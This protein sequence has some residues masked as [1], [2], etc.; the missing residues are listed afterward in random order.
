MT[1]LYQDQKNYALI[2]FTLCFISLILFMPEMSFAATTTPATTTST[3]A[4]PLACTINRIQQTLTGAL[5]K[6]IATIAIVA[7]GIGLFLGKLSWGL[8][9]ATSIGV[10]MI[11]GAGQVVTWLSGT[12]AVVPTSLTCS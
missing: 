3:S 2:A 11:F 12:S 5:G 9:I 6:G 10:G 8:A 4:D 7:L 1:N